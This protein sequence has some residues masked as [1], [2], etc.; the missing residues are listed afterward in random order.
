MSAAEHADDH[1]DEGTLHQA[2]WV[3]FIT[4]FACLAFLSLL[5]AAKGK[6]FAASAILWLTVISIPFQVY[7]AKK[8][9]MMTAGS[10]GLGVAGYFGLMFLLG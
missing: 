6:L 2:G 10:L 7:L 4:Y 8:D 1:G 9:W 5:M 3:Y